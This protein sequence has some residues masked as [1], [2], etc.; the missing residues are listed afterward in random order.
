[1]KT[2]QLMVT[3]D[4]IPPEGL[5][6]IL[7][8]APGP[9]AAMVATEAEEPPRILSPMT[10]AL[11]LTR[12]KSRLS[13]KGDFTVEVEIACDRCLN[14]AAAALR[15]EVDERLDLSPP[16]QK[17]ER[18]EDEDLDGGLEIQNG[19]VNL[20]GLLAELFWLAWP[21][22]YVCRPDCAG[23]CPRCGADLNGGPCACP[24]SGRAGD[25]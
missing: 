6:L 3:L 19:Q 17:P 11:H 2:P 8:V 5:N 20:A 1:M 21:F 23:L 13:V 16:G 7:N 25:V 9:L 4:D 15:G 24:Q 22:R 10:G 14:P 12:T 18:S